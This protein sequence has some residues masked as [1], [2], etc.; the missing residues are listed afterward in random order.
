M[1]CTFSNIKLNSLIKFNS[2]KI[3]DESNYIKTYQLRSHFINKTIKIGIITKRKR[4][5]FHVLKQA[6]KDGKVKVL[7][8]YFYKYAF[9]FFAGRRSFN[10]RV[11]FK[12]YSQGLKASKF[13]LLLNQF[14]MN[15]ERFIAMIEEVLISNFSLD[16]YEKLF[17]SLISD[18]DFNINFLIVLSKRG[19][20]INTTKF[21]IIPKGCYIIHLRKIL[22]Y[23]LFLIF[24]IQSL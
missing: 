16:F 10:F 3:K 7:H 19:K 22:W 13:S 18:I 6:E 5:K 2:G 21:V 12:E 1:C 11:T 8:S 4:P 23:T 15:L 9:G 17:G 14:N 24:F 20:F